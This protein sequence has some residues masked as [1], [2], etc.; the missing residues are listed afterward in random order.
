MALKVFQVLLILCLK[1]PL[2][3]RIGQILSRSGGLDL[4][5]KNPENW[6]GPGFRTTGADQVRT[7][8][9]TAKSGLFTVPICSSDIKIIV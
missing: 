9:P 6:L 1:R 2:D 7:S 8:G 3:F 4:R 5:T